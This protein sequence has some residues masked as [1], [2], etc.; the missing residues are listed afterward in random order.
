MADDRQNGISFI[1]TWKDV[2]AVTRDTLILI[3]VVSL[4]LFPGKINAALIK[5]GFTEGIFAGFT[6]KAKLDE[7]DQALKDMRANNTDLKTQNDDLARTLAEAKANVVDADLK[8]R[9]LDL[10]N[11]N[12]K[13]S[14]VSEK[15]A[16]SVQATIASTAPLVASVQRSQVDGVQWGVVYG[17][18]LDV[19]SAQQETGPVAKELNLPTAAIYLRQNYYRSVA[20]TFDRSDAEQ[21]LSRAKTHRGDAYIVNM[22]KW[23]P[24]PIQKTDYFECSAR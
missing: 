23:C 3:L 9:L 1:A 20:V 18:D 11:K 21:W 22:S 6:W 16:A 24:N 15:V 17:G 14:V 7:T 13:L 10:E 8:K 2:V 19:I 5:A 4:V 12:Q